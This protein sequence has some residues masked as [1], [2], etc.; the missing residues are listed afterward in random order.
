LV[1]TAES[2][3][4]RDE[5]GCLEGDTIRGARANAEAKRNLARGAAQA[6]AYGIGQESI[7]APE[8]VQVKGVGQPPLVEASYLQRLKQRLAV[9]RKDTKR[10]P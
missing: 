8:A 4:T 7:G 3:R 6:E 5:M 10:S 2:N 1:A 9:R